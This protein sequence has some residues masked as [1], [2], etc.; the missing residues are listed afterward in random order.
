MDCSILALGPLTSPSGAPQ[1]S[2]LPPSGFERS[3]INTNRPIKKTAVGQ[4][5]AVGIGR[6]PGTIPEWRRW[7]G[8]RD[9]PGHFEPAFSRTQRS[10][11]SYA[12][13]TIEQKATVGGPILLA[14]GAA[15][16]SPAITSAEG[17]P[18][19]GPILKIFN[20][21]TKLV[22]SAEGC[23]HRD[24]SRST[25]P[26]TVQNSFGFPG[27]GAYATRTDSTVAAAGHKEAFFDVPERGA[28]AA[29]AA[30][31]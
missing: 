12:V 18:H 21:A 16:T 2:A 14:F 24:P 8:N 26:A 30:G 3:T 28:C 15:T 25:V 10:P 29:A 27:R 5:M 1:Q 4:K 23:P 31:K 11:A 20:A 7:R 6:H 19:R 22:A 17:C 13:S 9:L